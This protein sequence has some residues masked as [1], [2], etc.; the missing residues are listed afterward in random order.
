[1][2]P[3]HPDL[4]GAV[5]EGANFGESA[6]SPDDQAGNGTADAAILAGRGHGEK[7]GILGIAPGAEIVPAEV[8]AAGSDPQ[9]RSALIAEAMTFLTKEGVDVISV[10]LPA[11]TGPK[12]EEAVLQAVKAGIPVVAADAASEAGDA[13]F[14]KTKG[15]V[16][17]IGTGTEGE[18]MPNAAPPPPADEKGAALAAPAAELPTALPG[19]GYGNGSEPSYAVQIIA[20]TLALVK[21]KQPDA[22]GEDLVNTVR[23]SASGEGE[24]DENLGYGIVSP[25]EALSDGGD[26]DSGDSVI[27]T[28]AG[29]N[30]TL[31]MVIA[32]VGV[33]GLAALV[34][35]VRS[36][37]R[38]RR[39]A[40]A[41]AAR[42]PDNPATG[43]FQAGHTGNLPR[44]TDTGAFQ[45]GHTGNLP[46]VTDTP[47]GG[48]PMPQ[49]QQYGGQP[50]RR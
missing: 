1:I 48:S 16:T 18:A 34:V 29:D 4:K 39:P 17:A 23:D 28:V 3:S 37:D 45:A 41:G 22:K 15:V 46:R 38:V 25:S 33:L 7:A 19:N 30:T 9:N 26:G 21:E 44:V 42:M 43:A 12:L 13:S 10:A 31:A 35:I 6:G 14:P 2:D 11:V 24:Y 47:P 5:T 36:R 32:G 40:P 20:G 49:Q 27:G 50:P 8:G